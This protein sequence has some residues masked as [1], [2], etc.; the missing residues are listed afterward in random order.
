MRSGSAL[1]APLR[2]DWPVRRAGA[3]TWA[4]GTTALCLT[5][6][7]LLA[8]GCG[9]DDAS[10]GAEDSIRAVAASFLR[11]YASTDEAVCSLASNAERKRVELN[12]IASGGAEKLSCEALIKRQADEYQSSDTSLLSG[13]ALRAAAETID[14]ANVSI[15][16]DTALVSFPETQGVPREV[17]SIFLVTEDGEWK[18][19]DFQ[20]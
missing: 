15:D 13:P 7:A 11:A 4:S 16:G 8:T 12:A 19:D 10:S 2:L 20:P 9:G 17:S 14:E 1:P 18:V 3:R 5:L 6:A